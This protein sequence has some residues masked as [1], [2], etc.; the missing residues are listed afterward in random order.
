MAGGKLESPEE[1]QGKGERDAR[2]GTVKEGR[3]KSVN[4]DE[5]R[6]IVREREIR[7]QGERERNRGNEGEGE[8][9]REGGNEGEGEREE[10]G[11][12][13]EVRG[14]RWRKN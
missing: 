10:K 2:S 3:R 7:R 4:R 11:E 8:G 12:G 5:E 14:E 9:E 13:V 1:G 6:G